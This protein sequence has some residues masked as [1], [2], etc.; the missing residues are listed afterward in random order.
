[1]QDVKERPEGIAADEFWTVRIDDY[2]FLAT[3][4][5]KCLRFVPIP[6]A[7]DPHRKIC[8]WVYKNNQDLVEAL[9]EFGV[10]SLHK[11]RVIKDFIEKQIEARK[12]KTSLE[13]D[14]NNGR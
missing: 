13:R 12:I 1:M 2:A 8:A 9:R 5:I 14:Q 10:P 3:K 4:A 11:T 6:S 7:R